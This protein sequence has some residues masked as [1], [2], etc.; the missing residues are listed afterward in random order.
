MNPRIWV[1]ALC[2]AVMTPGL[3]SAAI[4]GSTDQQVQ[5]SVNPL[6]DAVIQ[7][8]QDDNYELYT[9]YFN[10]ALKSSISQDRFK[11][12]DQQLS[13]MLGNYLYREYLGFLN[14]GA[15]TVVLWKGVFDR[16]ANDVL[17]KLVVSKNPGGLVITGLWFE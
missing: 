11:Q 9:K 4:V 1:T 7:G 10:P 6:L 2:L 8:L 12:I 14:K 15:F 13:E 3:L 5:D 17:I 16:A